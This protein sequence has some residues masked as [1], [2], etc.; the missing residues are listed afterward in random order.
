MVP[1][2]RIFHD[3]HRRTL[4]TVRRHA[5]A[6]ANRLHHEIRQ[7]SETRAQLVGAPGIAVDLVKCSAR[8]HAVT[9][10]DKVLSEANRHVYADGTGPTCVRTFEF[11]PSR[12]PGRLKMCSALRGGCVKAS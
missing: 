12:E 8:G 4:G 5:V 1:L 7:G 6:S 2:R 10:R 11:N 3:R 9:I